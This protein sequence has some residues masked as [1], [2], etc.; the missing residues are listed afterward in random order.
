ML[1]VQD[2]EFELVRLN[3]AQLQ[4]ARASEDSN[5]LGRENSLDLPQDGFLRADSPAVSVGSGGGASGHRSPTVDGPSSS[6]SFTNS[7]P[8]LLR[9]AAD[10]EF[11]MDT[12]RQRESKWMALMSMSPPAQAR[13]NKKVRKLLLEGVPSSVRYLVWIHLTDGKARCVPGVYSQLCSRAGVPASGEIEKDMRSRFFQN[14]P[15][16]QGTQG[17]VLSLLQAYF[18]MVPDIQYSRGM[19]PLPVLRTP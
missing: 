2:M 12:H 3:F 10:A 8:V 17:P 19:F 14:Q 16:L 7:S 11:S 18:N 1:Q 5:V 15:H 6:P 9:P 13:K 4:A